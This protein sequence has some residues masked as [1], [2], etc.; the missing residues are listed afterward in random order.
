MGRVSTEGDDR[1]FVIPNVAKAR[2]NQI[3]IYMFDLTNNAG[4]AVAK[5]NIASGSRAC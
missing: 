4:W 5:R 2:L 3:M 1:A